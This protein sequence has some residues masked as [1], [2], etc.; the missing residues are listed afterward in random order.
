MNRAIL[1]I[2]ETSIIDAAPDQAPSNTF[3]AARATL[4]PALVPILLSSIY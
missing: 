2:K 1:G 3:D 4:A